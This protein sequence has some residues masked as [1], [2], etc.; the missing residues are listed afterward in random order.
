E[1]TV[2][3]VDVALYRGAYRIHDVEI[4]KRGGRVPVP[5]VK[6]PLIDASVEWVALFDGRFVGE[7]VLDQPQLNFVAGPTEAEQ[8]SGA[9]GK[10]EWRRLVEGLFPAKLNRIEVRGGGIHF[11]NFRSEPPVDVELRDVDLV[12][13]NLEDPAHLRTERAGRVEM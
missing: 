9:A 1:G 8:Q 6:A 10:G 11:R 4:H 7:L 5:F 12:A 13:G 2:G 3:S